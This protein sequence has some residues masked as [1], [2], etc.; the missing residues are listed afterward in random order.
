MRRLL[1]IIL[2]MLIPLAVSAS[3]FSNL[4]DESTLSYWQGRYPKNVKYNFYEVILKAL[5][6]AE[7]Q[8]LGQVELRFPLIL[9][10]NPLGFY[11]DS[12]NRIL[13]MPIMGIKF[14]DDL[15]IANAW[16]V[17]NGFTMDSVY[18]YISMMK[19]NDPSRFPGG[20]Y[21]PP[22]KA[23]HVPADAYKTDPWVDD[24]SQ[25]ILKS[26]LVFIM[27]HELGH[28]YYNH[29]PRAF[30][31]SQKNEREADAFATE[32]LRRIGVVPAGI[33]VYFLAATYLSSNPGDFASDAKWRAFLRGNSHPFTAERLH[34]LASMLRE[35]PGDFARTEPNYQAS[36]TRVKDVAKEIDGI[37][38]IQEDTEFQRAMSRFTR[39]PDLSILKLR[40]PGQPLI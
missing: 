22:L 7:R 31:Q 16:L 36:L 35:R 2:L 1:L 25:K 10:D 38:R 23:L 5:T 3:K 4:Y 14:L 30:A 8:S 20:R 26:A 29:N 27:A 34:T 33:T 12:Q 19:Y 28:L 11:A 17:R 24:V 21:P 37:A 9:K 18:F 15:S 40:R 6:P 39:N 32:I 13:Y